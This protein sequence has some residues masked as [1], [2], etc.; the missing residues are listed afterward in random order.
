MKAEAA[1]KEEELHYF[2]EGMIMKNDELMR[3]LQNMQV[4]LN[5]AVEDVQV[6][7]QEKEEVLASYRRLLIEN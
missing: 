7:C 3:E 4:Q 2:R 1:A 6:L 5:A